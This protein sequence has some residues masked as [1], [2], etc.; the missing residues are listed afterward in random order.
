MHD[1]RAGLLPHSIHVPL[2][3]LVAHQ[4]LSASISLD[5][6]PVS[7]LAGSRLPIPMIE[8]ISPFIQSRGENTHAWGTGGQ[9][10]TKVVATGRWKEL[11]KTPE[12]HVRRTSSPSYGSVFDLEQIHFISMFPFL[13]EI[14]LDSLKISFRLGMEVH[15]YNP[16]PQE[17]GKGGLP[18]FQARLIHKTVATGP[19][20]GN[21]FLTCFEPSCMGLTPS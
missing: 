4:T 20:S 1:F 9:G 18:K 7:V 13:E 17:A 6:C 3:G 16:S 15:T 21:V 8:V 2:L 12:P 5:F 10:R 14:E 11:A 19:S